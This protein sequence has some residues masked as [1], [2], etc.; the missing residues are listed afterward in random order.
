MDIMRKPHHLFLSLLFVLP[1]LGF[2]Q[3][4]GI[5][6]AL[7]KGDA[8]AVGIYFCA[9][10]DLSIPGHDNTFAADKA[11]ILLSDFFSK[12][13]IKGYKKVHVSAPQQGRSNFT[14]GDLYTVKGT[15]RL[16]LFYNKDQKITEIE[17]S[18]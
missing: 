14:I 1:T 9:S 18:K 17:I 13:T 4:S 11:V 3:S 12:E 6:E 15:Y 10:V 5:D 16:T 8:K 2:C 7:S